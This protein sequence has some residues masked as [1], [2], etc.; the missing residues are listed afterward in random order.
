MAFIYDLDNEYGGQILS[1]AGSPGPALQVNSNAAGQPALAILS[2]ASAAAIQV[3]AISGQAGI[4]A[5]SVSTSVPAGNFRSNTTTGQALTISRTV[6][7]SPTVAPLVIT[8][9]SAASAPVVEFG[10]FVSITSVVLTSVANFDRAVRV[11]VGDTYRWIPLL[12]DAGLVGTGA[13]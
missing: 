11:K 9:A 6:A 12:L 8:N 4:L 13:F 1:D 3:K 2:T 7:S 5:D 10:S